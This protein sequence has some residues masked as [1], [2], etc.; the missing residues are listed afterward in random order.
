MSMQFRIRPLTTAD[1]PFLWEMLYQALFVPPGH[2]PFPRD[3]VREPEISRYVD[4]WG[5]DGDLGV[6]AVL[7]E[8]QAPIGAAWVRLLTGDECGYGWVDDETPELTIAVLP[9]S[10]GNGV[11]AQL[12]VQLIELA[13]ARYPA[14]SLSVSVENPARRLYERL[15][16]LTIVRDEYSLTMKKDLK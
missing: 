5:R 6:A 8:T 3:L 7:A 16:F 10:R 11:G 12:L 2:S 13:R 1:E 14:V 15:G 9:E 4:G